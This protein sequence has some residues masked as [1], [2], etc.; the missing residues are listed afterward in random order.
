MKMNEQ[1][2]ESV[3]HSLAS[4]TLQSEKE[5]LVTSR[6]TTCAAR[7]DSGASNH[8]R[9]FEMRVVTNSNAWY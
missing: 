8:L 2:R 4:H 3:V 9:C 6:T 1:D 5:G 7:Q